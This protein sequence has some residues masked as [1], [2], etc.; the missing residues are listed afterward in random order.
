[1][2]QELMEHDHPDNCYQTY[3]STWEHDAHAFCISDSVGQNRFE[4]NVVY[5]TV[6]YFWKKNVDDHSVGYKEA[7]NQ[8]DENLSHEN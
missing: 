5:L 1:M 2:Q 8:I 7:W 3:A 4:R 6:S